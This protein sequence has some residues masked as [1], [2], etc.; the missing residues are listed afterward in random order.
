MSYPDVIKVGDLRQ[1][2]KVFNEHG[3]SR[4]VLATHW[5]LGYSFI[6]ILVEGEEIARSL[7]IGQS[8]YVI[9]EAA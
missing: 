2:D 9:R 6:R 8:C 5:K 3:Q 1:G 7:P 4:E